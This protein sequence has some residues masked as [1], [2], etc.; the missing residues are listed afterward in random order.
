MV[1]SSARKPEGGF[2]FI[3]VVQLCMIWWAYQERRI[4]LRDVRVWFA[5][6]EL[7]ARRCQLKRGQTARYTHEELYELV[8]GGGDT[9]ASLQRLQRRG[10]PEWGPGAIGVSEPPPP[11]GGGAGLGA[12]VTQ[13]RQP[14]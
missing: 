5:A 4:R 1:F 11:E 13:S 10:V 14:T 6:H 7:L 12:G 3:S 2:R 9:P 8:G